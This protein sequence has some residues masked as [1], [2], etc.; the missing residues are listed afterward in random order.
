MSLKSILKSV[1]DGVKSLFN[2]LD[3]EKQA[4]IH[5]AVVAVEKMK[6]VLDSKAVDVLTF[7]IPGDTDNKLVSKG[8][9]FLPELLVWLKLAESMDLNDIPGLLIKAATNLS[10]LQ[11]DVKSAALRDISTLM[12]RDLTSMQVSFGDATVLS[13]NYY[14]TEIK[15]KEL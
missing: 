9:A 12:I 6:T 14:K 10:Q 1:W 3:K 15:G 5:I 13:E 2:G 7:L 8:R 11:G 4:A